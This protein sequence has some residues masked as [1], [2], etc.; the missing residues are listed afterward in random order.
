MRD[1]AQA[2]RDGQCLAGR[3]S[4]AL[5]EKLGVNVLGLDRRGRGG[6]AEEK[7]EQNAE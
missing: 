1:H 7:Q 5:G 4:A 3:G 6:G 2:Q